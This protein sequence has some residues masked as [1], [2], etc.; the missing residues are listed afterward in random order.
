MTIRLDDRAGSRE[1]YSP[2]LATGCKVQMCR[3]PYGDVEFDGVGPDECPVLVGV[4]H[5]QVSDVLKCMQDGR[6]SGHQLPGLLGRFNYTWLLVEGGYRAGPSGILQVET[7]GRW[8]DAITGRRA[9]RRTDFDS[10]LIGIELCGNIR[11]RRSRDQQDSVWWL[12]GIYSWFQKRWSDHR[13]HVGFDTSGDVQT[14]QLVAP[15]IVRRMAKEL[16]GVGWERSGAIDSVF[17]SPV[18][19]VSA[20]RDEWQGI[21]GIGRTMAERIMKEL[22]SDKLWSK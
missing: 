17:E 12:A 10:W 19:M 14:V 3:L 18:A 5:K 20:T 21:D 11:V 13:S 16:P 1:L 15:S 4:E 22:G 7:N 2:L 8:S 9:I 6:F